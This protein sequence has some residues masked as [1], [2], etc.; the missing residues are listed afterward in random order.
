MEDVVD[1][2]FSRAFDAVSCNILVGKLRQCGID[3]WT[4]RRIE[5]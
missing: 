5:N 2:D 1:L 3:E 4:V